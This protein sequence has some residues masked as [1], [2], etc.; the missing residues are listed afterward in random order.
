MQIAACRPADDSP[1]AAAASSLDSVTAVAMNHIGSGVVFSDCSGASPARIVMAALTAADEPATEGGS[2]QATVDATKMKA[3][4]RQ[5]ESD[6][7]EIKAAS[8]QP[9]CD[10]MP[11]SLCDSSLVRELPQAALAPLTSV[12]IQQGAKRSSSQPGQVSIPKAP[13][14]PPPPPPKRGAS[15][16]S[17]AAP[18]PPLPTRTA[19]VTAPSPLETANECRS[20]AESSQANPVAHVRS[21]SGGNGQIGSISHDPLISASSTGKCTSSVGQIPHH[22]KL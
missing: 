1:L 7:T 16:H 8:G 14:A 6:V 19:G 15:G 5:Q 3:N 11:S 4:G 22:S 18:K 9:G 17:R 21:S 20:D 10:L 2:Q 12:E 13:A